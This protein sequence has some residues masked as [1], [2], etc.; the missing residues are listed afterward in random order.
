[1]TKCVQ[2]AGAVDNERTVILVKNYKLYLFR[3]SFWYYFQYLYI[4]FQAVLAV[5]FVFFYASNTLI[6]MPINVKIKI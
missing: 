3:R 4:Y 6:I 1:V 5:V 2:H